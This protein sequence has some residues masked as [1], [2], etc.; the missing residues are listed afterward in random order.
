MFFIFFSKPLQRLAPI[1]IRN[2]EGPLLGSGSLKK[3]KLTDY[4]PSTTPHSSPT[5][6]FSHS[7]VQKTFDLKKGTAN[8]SH[9]RGR[10][11]QEEEGLALQEALLGLKNGNKSDVIDS[12]DVDK[13]HRIGRRIAI[14]VEC[15]WGLRSV[16][17]GRRYMIHEFG[18]LS[19]K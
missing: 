18:N 4:I 9:R 10:N 3:S 14:W 13:C 8:G 6:L 5:P 16:G 2:S 15:E 11:I 19:Q 12:D 7:R 1:L 17:G